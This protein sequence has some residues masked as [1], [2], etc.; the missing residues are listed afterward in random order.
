MNNQG[1]SF[2]TKGIFGF[3]F[4]VAL[5]F[6][7]FFI[8]KIVFKILLWVAPVLFLATLVINYRTVVNYFKFIMSLFQRSVLVGLIASILSIVGFPVLSFILFGKAIMD[9]RIRDMKRDHQ[10]REEGEYVGYEEV[11]R[12]R[13]DEN[14]DL[15]DLDKPEQKKS[16][17][18]YKDLF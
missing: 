12:Y 6:V 5:L 8:F 3:L 7:V 13:Q 14:L 10:L 4:L 11:P 18:K 2:R 1:F 17:N 16:D 9:R 15:P